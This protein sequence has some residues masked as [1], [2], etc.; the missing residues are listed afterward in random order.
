M[1]IWGRQTTL[2][3]DVPFVDRGTGRADLAAQQLG[4]FT[5]QGEVSVDATPARDEHRCTRQVNTLT[6]D[7]LD[8]ARTDDIL[9]DLHC[10]RRDRARA[11]PIS[12]SAKADNSPHSR[13]LE[14]LLGQD[15]DPERAAA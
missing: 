6:D 13:Q 3:R 1:A 14:P 5:E 7:A 11:R 10:Q 9:W 4:Q 2:A 8:D 12:F 15:G